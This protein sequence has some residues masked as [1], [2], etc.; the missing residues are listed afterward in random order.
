MN[1]ESVLMRLSF[2][3]FHLPIQA[4]AIC[5]EIDVA[6]ENSAQYIANSDGMRQVS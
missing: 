1:E 4:E 6:K 5:N 2:V 3:Q